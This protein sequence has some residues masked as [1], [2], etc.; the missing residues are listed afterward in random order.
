ME[1]I[2]LNKKQ[3]NKNL[4]IIGPSKESQFFTLDQAKVS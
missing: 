2:W 1:Q 4:P 3:I